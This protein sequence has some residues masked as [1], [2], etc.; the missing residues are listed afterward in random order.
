[1][2]EKNYFNPHSRTGSDLVPVDI[3][4]QEAD[5]NPHSRTGSD[6]KNRQSYLPLQSQNYN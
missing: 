4:E 5:F 2:T 6:S 1:M 3:L